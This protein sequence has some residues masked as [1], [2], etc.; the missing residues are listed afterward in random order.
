MPL[1][2]ELTYYEVIGACG[3]F[4]ALNKP[5]SQ[6]DCGVHLM[7]VGAIL[8]LLPPP[9][10]RVLECG[11]GTGW[12]ARILQKRGYDVVGTD[13][14]PDAIDLARNNT[15]FDD[16]EPLDFHVADSEDLPFDEEFDAVVFFDALHHCIDE[17]AAIDSA[18]RALKPGGVC[19][20]SETNRGHSRK[21]RDVAERYDVTEKDM[22]PGLIARLGRAAGFRNAT[23]YPRADNIGACLF[24]RQP[25][26]R[27]WLSRLMQ[28]FRFLRYLGVVRLMGFVKRNRGIIVLH[29]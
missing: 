26:G 9:P 11:C 22:P 18:Y 2:G 12:L 15:Y 4:H 21:A 27:P 1:A 28:R 25:T 16:A 29:K 8:E 7:Q 17:Q 24:G 3:R 23:F 19:I 10:A 6:E 20:A 14:A 13:V 5:F